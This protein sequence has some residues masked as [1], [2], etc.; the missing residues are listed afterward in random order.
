MKLKRN[1]NS[2]D[3]ESLLNIESDSFLNEDNEEELEI[4][5]DE[6]VE[7]IESKNLNNDLFEDFGV[8]NEDEEE[9]SDGLESILKIL[10]EAKSQDEPSD[11]IVDIGLDKK[12][13]NKK[14]TKEEKKALKQMKK[15]QKA[16]KRKNSKINGKNDFIKLYVS[17]DGSS[18]DDFIIVGDKSNK[19][20]GIGSVLKVS[21][22]VVF[23]ILLTI[24]IAFSLLFKIVPANV[25]GGD[26]Y[27]NNKYS[28]VSRDHQPNLDEL[29]VNDVVLL[30][31][32][33]LSWMPITYSFNLYVCKNRK[34]NFIYV[35]D[36]DGNEKKIEYSEI[37]YVLK[38]DPNFKTE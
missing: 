8:Y 28:I 1:K 19:L 31:D 29:K 7:N 23:S 17:M 5:K 37:D 3:I 36:L 34:G 35:N 33:N 16:L 20:S 9:E 24:L 18:E 10:N 25:K 14:L 21:F 13:K 11:E 12:D 4:M 32:E 30:E 2:S 27:I 38:Y 26:M 6:E 15:E 22:I